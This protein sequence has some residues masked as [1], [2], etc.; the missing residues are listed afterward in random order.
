LALFSRHGT[1]AWICL[2]K[3]D[4]ETARI[5]LAKKGD[6][7]EGFVAG[8]KA[9]DLYGFRVD[10]PWAPEMGH[11]FDVTKLLADPYAQKLDRP[12]VY[13]AE[14]AQRGTDT[15][16]FVPKCVVCAALPDLPLRK[17][18]PPQFIYELGVKAFTQLHPDVPLA[19]RGTLAALTE[20]SV[21]SHL[22]ALHVDCIELMPINPWIDERHLVAL[23]LH[24]AWGYNSVQFMA[25]DPRLAP[26]G[27]IELRDTIAT[28]HEHGIQVVLDI[29]FNHSGESDQFG[30]TLSF[31]GLDHASYYALTNG[32]LHNDAGCGN[33]LA[34]NV[35]PAQGMVLDVLR[36]FVLKCGIDGFRFDLA[37]VLGRCE[38]SFEPDS[39]LLKAIEADP[40]L[41]SRIMI[42]EPWDVGPGGYQLGQFPG[43]WLEWNDQ[44]R[45]DVRRF[46]RGDPW[47]TNNFATRLAGSSDI[48]GKRKPSSSVNFIAAHDGFTLRDI[49]S[50]STK[51]NEANGENNRDGNGS[52][53]TWPGGDV[54][55]LLA[56]L[57][58]SRG[59]VMLTAGDEFG[60]T[61]SGNNNAYAQ[62]N[63]TTWLEWNEA[64]KELAS[65]V[66]EL[67]HVRATFRACFAD[68]FIKPENSFWFGRDGGALNW[69]NPD[70]DFV[71]LLITTEKMR[72]C[73]IVNRGSADATFPLKAQNGRRW[74]LQMS[75]KPEMC[76]A[77]SVCF[78]TE[79]LL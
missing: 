19:K 70:A 31:R 78:L 73:I 36:H 32:E 48:F 35:T 43:H 17:I 1:R 10:G 59:T 67:A 64:D 33:T 60:R 3:D 2:F 39:P 23:G 4:V 28:L 12:Y 47:A 56:T 18:A 55:A 8:L 79:Q 44:Y 54:R 52:E 42:A 27:L 66:G 16:P 74:Q 72:C 34:L 30:P 20:P 9:G 45:D 38:Y 22:K 13:R 68:E 15:A 71:G 65:F 77:K 40:V 69:S 5:E 46:W 75:S 11:R 57:F 61:Q 62:D 53:A 7:F 21:L 26:G 14:L 29:V 63:E 41:N 37:T 25:V 50:Y 51:R 49:V 58:M 76:A 6:L 24:N